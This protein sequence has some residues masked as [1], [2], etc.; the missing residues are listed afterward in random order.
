MIFMQHS[1]QMRSQS[2]GTPAKL[3]P[4]FIEKKNTVKSH[5][6]LRCTPLTAAEVA[7][8]EKSVLA[9]NT[10]NSSGSNMLTKVLTCHVGRCLWA[11][12]V[13][14]LAQAADSAMSTL[15][16]DRAAFVTPQGT[17]LRGYPC[18]VRRKLGCHVGDLS[19]FPRSDCAAF[20]DSIMPDQNK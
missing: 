19:S 8:L 5:L 12:S 2:T 7:Y 3:F 1:Q 20:E 13:I 4:Q 18:L 9:K 17:E 14:S 11:P 10:R 6:V 16:W 15:L